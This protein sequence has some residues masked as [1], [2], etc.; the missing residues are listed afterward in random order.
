MDKKNRYLFPEILFTFFLLVTVIFLLSDI[1][2]VYR[3]Y[4]ILGLIS[5]FSFSLLARNRK[6]SLTKGFVN[7]AVLAVFAWI[8]Y[9]LLNSS[10]LYREVIITF[11]KGGIILEIILSFDSCYPRSLAIAQALSLPLFMCFAVF[12]KTY[13]EAHVVLVLVYIICWIAI[14]RIK[15]YKLFKPDRETSRYFSI[16]LSAIFFLIS[17]SMCLFLFHNLSLG[18][19]KKGGFLLQEN[20]WSQTESEKEDK[21]YYDL[22]DKA[23]KEVLELI[24]EFISNKERQDI[25]TLLSTLIKE[26]ASVMEVDKAQFG[27]V[28]HLKVP[29]PGIEKQKGEEAAVY[30][31]NYLDKK[32]SFNLRNI[33]ESIKDNLKKDRFNIMERISIMNRINK[34]QRGSSAGQVKEYAREI[35]K[36]IDNSS[37]KRNSKQVLKRLTGLYEEWKMLQLYRE[38]RDSLDKKSGDLNEQ[39]KQKLKNFISDIN[40]IGKLSELKE[41][42]KQA[43]MLKTDLSSEHKDAAAQ[44]QGLLNLKSEILLSQ[45]AGELKEEID[46]L[47]LPND[48]SGDFKGNVDDIKD[49]RNYHDFSNNLSRLR[50]KAEENRAN[51]A[52]TKEFLEVKTHSIFDEE[53]EKFKSKLEES[54]LHDKG[55]GLV[56]DLEKLEAQKKEGDLVSNSKKL[57]DNMENLAREGFISGSTKDSLIKDVEEVKN[58]FQSELNAE[59]ESGQTQGIAKEEQV[60]GDYR[61]DWEASLEKSSLKEEKK[62]ALRQLEK[63]LSKAQTI[64]QI[65]NIKE[66]GD[67]EIENSSKDNVKKEQIKNMRDTFDSMVD[68]K[69]MFIIEKAIAA[70]REKIECLRQVNPQGAEEIQNFLEK[71]K[72]SRTNEQLKDQIDVLKEYLN[73][74]MQ[75]QEKKSEQIKETSNLEIHVLPSH[76]VIP[77]GSAVSLKAVAVYNK[78]FIKEPGSELEWFSSQPYV[79]WVDEEGIIHSLAKGKTQIYANYNG[80]ESQKVSV[81]VVDKIDEQLDMAVERESIR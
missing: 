27:L 13:N 42:Q 37:A 80:R 73:S 65:Q 43:E 68:V 39:L 16:F 70:L 49:S 32:I 45:K 57:K 63:D 26:S 11:I 48:E 17:I 30:L 71:T 46:N 64:S 21:E 56:E 24:P 33:Q 6:I 22:Q 67:K 76:L 1:L 79:A 38:K 60:Q 5:A 75:E 28:S 23:Q 54:N 50:D 62:D 15:F 31:E 34:M 41:T 20:E 12:V 52:G 29:G 59:K 66:T 3:T 9:S 55:A 47:K 51:L 74:K 77:V 35:K 2:S 72:N 8:I 25:L 40:N 53:K 14:L 58:L 78:V 7:I 10:L 4:F 69:R 18:E 36:L 19:I 61:K 81:T 44:M